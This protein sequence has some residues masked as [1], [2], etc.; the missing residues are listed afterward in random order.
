MAKAKV[1]AV[2]K[3]Q[4]IAGG[5]QETSTDP[6]TGVTHIKVKRTVSK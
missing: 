6:K 5:S 1:E 3:S 4:A 2:V